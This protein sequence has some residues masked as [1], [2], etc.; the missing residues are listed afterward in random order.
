MKN[1]INTLVVIVVICGLGSSCNNVSGHTEATPTITVENSQMA[2][3]PPA[4]LTPVNVNIARSNFDLSSWKIKPLQ[5]GND[6]K[7]SFI[8]IS[9]DSFF[10]SGSTTDS[11]LLLDASSMQTQKIDLNYRVHAYDGILF[12]SDHAKLADRSD[13]R[14]FVI[15]QNGVQT[16]SLPNDNFLIDAYLKDGRIRLEHLWDNENGY[17]EGKGLALTYYI[18]DPTTGATQKNTAFLPNYRKGTALRY[19][20]G[21]KYVLYRS[22]AYDKE[23]ELTLFDLEKDKVVWVGPPKDENLVYL[24]DSHPNWLPNR[25]ILNLQSLGPAWMPN[26]DVLTA[27]FL[28]KST[29]QIKYYSISTEG[30]ISPIADFDMS[31][32][33]NGVWSEA[34]ASSV[35]NIPTW[36]PNGRYL[37][38]MGKEK[39]RGNSMY[40]WDSQEN[41]VYKPCLPNET[42]TIIPP[43]II[44]YSDG[45]SFIVKLTFNSFIV[46]EERAYMG[47]AFKSYFLDPSKK[48]VYEIPS[49]N[50]AEGSANEND[51]VLKI[52]FG[53]VNWEIP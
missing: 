40:I 44:Q 27:L 17:E 43:E 39:D 38:T 1:W 31:D 23:A 30:D 24:T 13:N 47:R 42:E 25:N 21:M 37:I 2:T 3:L 41:I 5:A 48:I 6:I 20:L 50:Q 10:V 51:D 32:I 49:F 12:S 7:G 45:S 8:Y 16:Y 34:Q 53:W 18:F 33:V 22:S 4:T 11:L 15:D 52:L 19:S 46:P 29:G 26:A 35:V 9:L 36:T 14:I 28:D